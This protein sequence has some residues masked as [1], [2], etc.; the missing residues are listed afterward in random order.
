MPF[1]SSRRA[2]GYLGISSARVVVHAP[3]PRTWDLD[4]DP[5]DPR[6]IGQGGHGLGDQVGVDP[7]VVA[8]VQHDV[9]AELTHGLHRRELADDRPERAAHLSVDQGAWTEGGAG[10]RHRAS[11]SPR[12]RRSGREPAPPGVGAAV[13]AGAAVVGGSVVDS[14]GGVVPTTAVVGGTTVSSATVTSFDAGSVTAMVVTGS[15]A[16][17]ALAIA[18]WP[19][20]RLCSMSLTGG[21]PAR[22]T[23]ATPPA[24][25]M[26]P[27]TTAAAT[28]R[29][30]PGRPDAHGPSAP[31]TA[32]RCAGWAAPPGGRTGRPARRS[33]RGAARA[34]ASRSGLRRGQAGSAR[35]SA[36][37]RGRG[38]RDEPDGPGAADREHRPQPVPGSWRRR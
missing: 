14:V 12:G 25:T 30:R 9:R 21:F 1:Q 29:R 15:V 3:L 33:G 34:A 16:V 18:S 17:G 7:A 37:A 36:S 5:Q 22:M 4:V 31:M 8:E 6:H 2:F 19:A 24:A 27:S 13:G 10:R 11:P 32:A 38:R 26:V 20:R 28:G 23:T 35:R